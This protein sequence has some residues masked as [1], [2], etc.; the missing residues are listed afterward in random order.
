MVRLPNPTANNCNSNFGSKKEQCLHLLS[1]CS[2]FKHLSQIHA[3]IQVSG[4]QNDHFLLTQLIRFCALS[5]AKN[6]AYARTLLDHSESS[7][8]SSWNFLIRGCASSDSLREAI[9]VFRAMLARGVRPNQLTFPFLIKSCASAAALKEGRQVHVGVVKCGLDC[10]VYVQ[11]NLVHFYGECKKINDARKV[12]DEMSER[13]VVS[14]N[15]VITAC[16]ENFW[17]DEGIEYFVKMRGCGFEPDETTMVVVL[18]ASSELGNLSIGRWVHSQLIERGL[19]LNCQLGTALVDMY[20]KSG[21]LGYARIVFNKM[22][23]R[24]VW[25][26]SA[27]IL[28][29]AQHGFAKEALEIFL[30]MLS[31]SVRPNYV[32]F[33][34]VLC[35]CSH[36]GLVED[37]YRY[38]NDMEHV[39]GIKPMM[40]HYGAMVDILGRAGR[41][42]EAYSFLRSMPLDPGPIVWR[43]LLSACTTHSAEDNEGVGNKV[44]EKLLE[45]EPKR[46]GNLVMVA[47]MYAEVGMWEKAAN[48]RK[49]MKERRMK[50]MAGESCIELGGSVHKFF[51]GYDSQAGYE[52]IYQLL[53]VLS[54]HMK[55]VNM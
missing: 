25:T 35:A 22:E 27:M 36:A 54:L 24:N 13:S 33:L 21:N 4:F 51:S 26:W 3:Q 15:A 17:L 31:S 34:G 29:L 11:N 30:K 23:V 19:A 55:L 38:F 46:G 2:T 32:T 7:P 45:L 44:R 8:P 6:F 12:F 20:A 1:R 48:L 42:N 37:G 10:D 28:G 39:H 18:N 49:V 53:D 43:T 41:L 50:K 9:W 16:V 47:N 14:W 52:T 5:P 40:V